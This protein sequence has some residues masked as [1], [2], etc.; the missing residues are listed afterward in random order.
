M[1]TDFRYLFNDKIIIIYLIFLINSLRYALFVSGDMDVM[2][3]S[4]C[5]FFWIG[6]LVMIFILLPS[7]LFS[8]VS[9][10]QK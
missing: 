2:A 9:I 4:I 8:T 5:A 6:P 7:L 10:V 1:V 3:A